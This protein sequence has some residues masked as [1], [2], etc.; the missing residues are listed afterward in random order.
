MPL[1][2]SF[3][4]CCTGFLFAKVIRKLLLRAKQL[5]KTCFLTWKVTELKGSTR[6]KL[7]VLPFCKSYRKSLPE[8]ICS[9]QLCQ[10][11]IIASPPSCKH[12]GLGRAAS[13]DS[14]P[15]SSTED[16]LPGVQPQRS[17]LGTRSSPSNKHLCLPS[18]R[19]HHGFLLQV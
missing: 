6:P 3:C 15:C 8:L 9:E 12:Y 18:L 14:S 17:I 2:I 19:N 4:H 5:I 7:C 11:G 16:R 1:K 10:P 13:Q